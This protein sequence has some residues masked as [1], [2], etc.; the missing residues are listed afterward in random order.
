MDD[1][2]PFARP[3]IGV[4]EEEAAVRVLRSGWLTTGNEAL[5][6]EA[7]FAA[8]LQK[9]S[10]FHD[11]ALYARAVNSATSGLHLA[12]EAAGVG[13]GDVVLL[14]SYTFAASAEVVR[15]LDAEAAFV[16]TAP[17][18]FHLDVEKLESAINRLKEGKS[19]YPNGGPTGVPKA[20]IPVHFGG[21]LRD[22]SEIYRIAEKYSLAVIEDAAH[23]LP[24]PLPAPRTVKK[25][26]HI[27]VFSFYATKPLATGE[28]GMLVT[29]DAGLAE[30]VSVM[31]LHGIDRPIWNRY[32]GQK[33][34]WYYEVVEAGYKYNMCDILAAVGREQ[35]KRAGALWEMRKA[36][37]GRYDG[38]FSADARFLIPP[39]GSSDARHL[40]P[41]RLNVQNAPLSRD[42]FITRLAD[43]GVGASVHFIPLHIMPYYAKRYGIQPEDFPETLKSFQSEISLPIWQGMSGAQIERVIKAVRDVC[44]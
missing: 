21:L 23:T 40:Y 26:R 12:L 30:R 34:S 31:R 19:A 4:E 32:S 43:E 42:A 22:M 27:I 16:D 17:D 41:L 38:A 36:I 44:R 14:P 9:D 18:S 7:E 8:F 35:L 1:Y 2:I 20:V 24:Y 33:A 5:H 3:F 13:R 39:T 6:F 37:A 15:Y 29:G 10:P 25:I 11:H 28:G